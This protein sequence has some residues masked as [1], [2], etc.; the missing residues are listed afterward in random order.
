MNQ[1]PGPNVKKKKENIHLATSKAVGLVVQKVFDWVWMAVEQEKTGNLV[2]NEGRDKGEITAKICGVSRRS[3]YRAKDITDQQTAHTPGRNRIQFD[4]FDKRSLSRLILGYYKKTP[5][6]IPTL[7]MIHADAIELPGFP[8]VSRSTIH[9]LIIKEG[10]VFKK[11]NMKM[12][13][14]Q[15]LDIVASRHRVLRKLEEYRRDGYTLFYQDE[16]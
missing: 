13:I 10:F 11:R 1:E 16:T 3:V 9:R 4:E 8:S 6:V 7:D 15:R 5:P 2:F 14:Y 12:N